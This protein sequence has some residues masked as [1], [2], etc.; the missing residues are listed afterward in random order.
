MALSTFAHY[1]SVGLTFGAP[2]VNTIVK[3]CISLPADLARGAEELAH[4][5]SKTLSCL[6][7]DALRMLVIERR[8]HKLRSIQKYWS[9]VARDKGVLT[10]KDLK[11]FLHA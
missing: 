2:N 8:R 11:R 10:E 6:I 3:K 7:Q 1:D 9:R 5:E 4:T